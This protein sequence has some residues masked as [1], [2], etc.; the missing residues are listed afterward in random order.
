MHL[1]ASRTLAVFSRQGDRFGHSVV[2]RRESPPPSCGLESVLGTSL[3]QWPLDPPVQQ[4]VLEPLGNPARVAALGVGMSGGGHWSLATEV[5]CGDTDRI[6]FDWACRI[7]R[8]AERLGSSYRSFGLTSLAPA[9]LTLES[10]EWS[11]ADGERLRLTV[12]EGRIV[13][14]ER[15]A[16]LSIIPVSDIRSPGT[17]TWRYCLGVG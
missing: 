16:I 6:Q 10:A 4:L 15:E 5:V 14:H 11:L 7:H 2:S 17:H 9:Q 8:P 1:Q 12:S 3:E 13:W